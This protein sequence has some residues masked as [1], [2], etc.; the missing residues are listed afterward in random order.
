MHNSNETNQLFPSSLLCTILIE[1]I[2]NEQ[3]KINKI[4]ESFLNISYDFCLL[5]R[6]SINFAFVLTIRKSHYQLLKFVLP[7]Y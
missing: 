4:S 2:E 5:Q 7:N 3:T 6:H 1:K